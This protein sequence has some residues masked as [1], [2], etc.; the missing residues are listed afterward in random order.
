MDTRLE[1]FR[2]DYIIGVLLFFGGLRFLTFPRAHLPYFVSRWI[3]LSRR[4]VRKCRTPVFRQS[5]HDPVTVKP[6]AS[7]PTTD[8]YAYSFKRREFYNPMMSKNYRLAYGSFWLQFRQGFNPFNVCIFQPE[9]F[10][11]GT[12]I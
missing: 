2:A 11:I 9:P 4:G 1:D 8:Y 7:E 6:A 3:V 5:S 12:L 10:A